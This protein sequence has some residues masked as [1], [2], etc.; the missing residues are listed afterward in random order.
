MSMADLTWIALLWW[1]IHSGDD[2]RL[3]VA[4]S[5]QTDIFRRRLHLIWS[6]LQLI[7]DVATRVYF[8]AY[9]PTTS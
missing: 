3:D 9:R 1:R 7:G 8:F 5:R 6:R 4:R 2:R